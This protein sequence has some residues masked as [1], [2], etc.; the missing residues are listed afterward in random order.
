[1]NQEEVI[2]RLNNHKEEMEQL[3]IQSLAI[4][5]STI[6]NEAKS[7]SDV[8]LL[9]KFKMPVGLLH[10]MRVRRRLSEILGVPVDLTTPD[11]L[12]KEMRGKILK[13]AVYAI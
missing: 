12:R 6:H 5:G 3:K 1:M 7:T 8:D 11:S 2:S 4:F 13:E 9:V 10:F